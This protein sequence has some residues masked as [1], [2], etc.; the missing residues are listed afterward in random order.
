MLDY[1][2]SG[3]LLLALLNPFLVIVY[4]I[5]VLEK[6]ERK[7]FQKVLLRAGVIAGIVFCC[8]SI[9]GDAIF[10][11]VIHAEFASFQIFGGIVFLL[12]G[13]Q[14]VLQGPSAIGLLR[15]ESKH[16]AGAIAMPILIGPGSISASIIIGEKHET[17]IACSIVICAVAISITIM[18]ILKAV[19]DFIHP[20]KENLVQRYIEIAGRIQALYIGTIS[21]EMIMSGLRNWLGKF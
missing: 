12:I 17:W 15:G 3:S 1:L 10:S 13:I 2:Q 7:L 9:L 5:D 14:F 20:K 11:N 4:L 8:F 16:I 6:L 21:I 18:I 19:Y